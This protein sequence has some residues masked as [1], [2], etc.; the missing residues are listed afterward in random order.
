MSGV[1]IY[2]VCMCSVCFSMFSMLQ[3]KSWLLPTLC[4]LRYDNHHTGRSYHSHITVMRVE[5]LCASHMMNSWAA[6]EIRAFRDRQLHLDEGHSQDILEIIFALWL[7]NVLRMSLNGPDPAFQTTCFG[8]SASVL[9]HQLTA[10]TPLPIR[11]SLNWNSW[12]WLEAHTF[13]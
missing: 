1:H 10:E 4:M 6:R 5:G 9:S 11:Y 12:S 3:H 13:Q 8:I 2:A 7:Q